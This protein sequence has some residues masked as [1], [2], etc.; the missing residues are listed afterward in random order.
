MLVGSNFLQFLIH[1]RVLKD[2]RIIKSSLHRPPRPGPSSNW[3][4]SSSRLL[5]ISLGHPPRSPSMH[6]HSATITK[7]ADAA[8]ECETAS[9]SQAL[10]HPVHRCNH[11]S[12]NNAPHKVD[13]THS[14]SGLFRINVDQKSGGKVE[15][16]NGAK[17]DKKVKTKGHT[18]CTSYSMV[19]P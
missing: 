11:S 1:I 10:N 9:L 5:C 15:I 4:S 16:G 14:R 8:N 6:S 17:R 19:H 7:Q 13:T 18:Y 3:D 12:G 2:R